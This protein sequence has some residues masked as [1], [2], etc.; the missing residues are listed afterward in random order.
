MSPNCKIVSTG[1]FYSQEIDTD[2][3]SVIFCGCGVRIAATDPNPN[4]ARRKVEHEY[5]EHLTHA[6]GQPASGGGDLR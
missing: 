5:Q 6:D 3:T 1:T 2:F 4:I